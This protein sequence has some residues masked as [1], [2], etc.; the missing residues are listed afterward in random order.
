MF[1]ILVEGLVALLPS[2]DACSIAPVANQKE[3]SLIQKNFL[4][5]I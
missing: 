5:T 4:I 3:I 1:K 2:S